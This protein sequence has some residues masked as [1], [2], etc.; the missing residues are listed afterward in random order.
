MKPALINRIPLAIKMAIIMFLV[1]TASW[2]VV[3]RFE[4][5][6]LREFFLGYHLSVLKYDAQENLMRF[7]QHLRAR[8]NSVRSLVLQ[9]NFDGYVSNLETTATKSEEMDTIT[10]D[11]EQPPWFPPK[12]LSRA[13]LVSSYALLI[14]ST[15][16]ARE[17]YKG[18][19][20]PLP[21][22]LLYPNELLP[23]LRNT[24]SILTNIEGKPYQLVIKHFTY[25]HSLQTGTLMVAFP[26]N[27]EFMRASQG[28]ILGNQVVALMDT[29]NLIIASSSPDHITQGTSLESLE[30]E[31]LNTQ[32]SFFDYGESEIDIRFI[33]L[34]PKSDINLLVGKVAAMEFKYAIAYG[35]VFIL[36]SSLVVLFLSGKVRKVSKGIV[37]FLHKNLGI[38]SRG[39]CPGH[40]AAQMR[41]KISTMN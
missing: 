23:R 11:N 5:N 21:E 9:S 27:D 6:A 30:Q 26:I 20:R 32:K 31:Y 14:D 17:V 36:C 7:I 10:Y 19:Q 40:W 22:T 39:E 37:D 16:K 2:V 24:E 28:A 4:V 35:I 25:S 1:V 3:Q 8:R 18:L 34:F 41:Q 38:E 29:N 12:T 33:S 13:H 15:G